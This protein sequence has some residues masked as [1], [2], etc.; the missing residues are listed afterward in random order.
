MSKW[1]LRLF[2]IGGQALAT[3]R[4][5]LAAQAAVE[6]L[7]GAT[8]L[9]NYLKTYDPEAHDGRG[10]AIFTP[11]VSEAL[12]FDSAVDALECWR[13]Q[14]KKRPLRDDGKPKRPLTAFNMTPERISG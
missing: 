1:T 12:K 6:M 14:S 3:G 7:E 4:S 2:E 13:T 5:N 8:V 9:G 10:S 11:H